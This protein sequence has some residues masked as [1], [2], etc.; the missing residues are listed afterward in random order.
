[1]QISIDNE[2]LIPI[3]HMDLNMVECENRD[4]GNAWDS[5]RVC[6]IY[7]VLPSPD[8]LTHAPAC[9]ITLFIAR[10]TLHLLLVCMLWRESDACSARDEGA[11]LPISSICTADLFQYLIL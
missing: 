8:H 7:M 3:S 5:W 6:F 2:K 4:T 11:G 9:L 1:M 10:N